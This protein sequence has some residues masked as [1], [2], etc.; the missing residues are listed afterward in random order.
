M[1]L[2]QMYIDD[3]GLIS[4]N[5]NQADLGVF[6][7]IVSMLQMFNGI[8]EGTLKDEKVVIEDG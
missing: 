2:P 5:R 8:H 1:V 4:S 7:S 3:L 6:I